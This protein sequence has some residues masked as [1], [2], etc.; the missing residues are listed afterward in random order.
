MNSCVGAPQSRV[1]ELALSADRDDSD[2]TKT[3]DTEG[4]P[5]PPSASTAAS[6]DEVVKVPTQADMAEHRSA[7]KSSSY[8]TVSGSTGRQ[9]AEEIKRYVD[10]FRREETPAF[11]HSLPRNNWEKVEEKV[12][13]YYDKPMAFVFNFVYDSLQLSSGRDKFC[14]LLQGYAKFASAA[15]AEP[16]SEKYWMYRGMEDSL[17]DGRKI[18]RF[19][20]EIREVYKVRRGFHRMQEGVEKHGFRSIPAACGLL[21]ILG[22]TASFFFY[23]LDNLLWATSVGIFR[24]KAV[25]PLQRRMWKGFRRNGVVVSALGGVAKIKRNKNLASIW[26]LNFAI[27]ANVLLLSRTLADVG[28]DSFRGPD[29]P[30]LF[31]TLEIV[32]MAASFRVLLSK[33]NVWKEGHARLGLLAI[34]A[35]ACGIWTNWRKVQRKNCGA[36]TFVTTTQ[37]RRSSMSG[38]WPP[39]RSPARGQPGSE[40][41]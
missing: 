32:G 9:L 13:K 29:D 33:L 1:A 27:I 26:R 3:S 35:A 11:D 22:H 38:T 18:F 36:K 28:G 5:I 14:A 20:K 39:G 4:R 23:I 16:D 30:R 24:A 41:G 34:V 6:D 17:S 21:D 7:S 15:L 40:K 31:H 19:F 2:S 10:H 12:A 25:P 8:A 37:R